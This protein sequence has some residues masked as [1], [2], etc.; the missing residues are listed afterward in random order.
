MPEA[1]EI[2]LYPCV[3]KIVSCLSS[4][5]VNST[6]GG[7]TPL[8][9]SCDCFVRGIKEAIDVPEKPDLQFTCPF[10]CVQSIVRSAS[11]Y[12]TKING[13][14]GA[15]LDCDSSISALAS[16]NFG[17]K[18]G[19]IAGPSET[20]SLEVLP[21]DNPLVARA[22]DAIR[23][24]IN[25]QRR[26]DCP[27]LHAYDEPGIVKY[28]K[29]GIVASGGG[30]YR[31]EVVFGND[32]VF[33]RVVHLPKDRQLIDPT[34]QT[35]L[36]DPTNLDGRFELLSSVPGPCED[37]EPEQLAVSAEGTP[38]L[39]NAVFKPFPL[40]LFTAMSIFGMWRE[41]KCSNDTPFPDSDVINKQ[42]R[43]WTASLK[44]EHEGKRVKDFGLGDVQ[45]S[46]Q[47][48]KVFYVQLDTTDFVAPVAYDARDIYAGQVPCKAYQVLNQGS[49]GS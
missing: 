45:L 48:R 49:C 14:N 42:T 36:D 11:H 2:A 29:R 1:C 10:V 32:V 33:G 46:A 25:S 5:L 9:T 47:E 12:V 18:H 7:I 20:D 17:N 8:T 19:Y 40:F 13:P 28:A 27:A 44:A 16:D 23:I 26:L 38:S 35:A 6:G 41:P 37:G 39:E 3:D 15:A 22:A 30:Q 21:V 4:R 34:A 24:S 43:T 31:L